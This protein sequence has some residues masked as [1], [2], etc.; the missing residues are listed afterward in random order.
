MRLGRANRGTGA[1]WIDGDRV[2]VPFPLHGAINNKIGIW[3]Y[4]KGGKPASIIKQFG[5][6]RGLQ[7]YFRGVTISVAPGR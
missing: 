4:T 7:L 3:K 5:D 6:Y 1:S 2:V